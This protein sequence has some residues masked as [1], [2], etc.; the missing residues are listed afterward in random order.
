MKKPLVDGVAISDT[1]YG[2]G[3]KRK[4]KKKLPTLCQNYNYYASR[5]AD[6]KVPF[7][8]IRRCT[9][10]QIKKIKR[11]GTLKHLERMANLLESGDYYG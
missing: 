6:D 7:I 4:T 9:D 11:T 1:L 10:E 2:F 3:R 8:Q 5:Y